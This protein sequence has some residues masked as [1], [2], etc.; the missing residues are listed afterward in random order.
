MAKLSKLPQN[1]L[2]LHMLLLTKRWETNVLCDIVFLI[3]VECTEFS[4]TKWSLCR[5]D[6]TT[7][8]INFRVEG[9]KHYKKL[10]RFASYCFCHFQVLRFSAFFKE[11]VHES[12]DEFYRVRLV[13]IYYYLE[14]DSISVIEPIVNNSGIPQV[15]WRHVLVKDCRTLSLEVISCCG[16]WHLRYIGSCISNY[17][18]FAI[19][20][21]A[22][23]PMD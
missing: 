1:H 7:V 2:F 18:M 14:D 21:P 20:I 23:L 13:D 6:T 15:R 17:Q 8:Y 4:S 16:I 12:S 9:C 19:F 10:Y 3:W 22:I 5:S 11:T